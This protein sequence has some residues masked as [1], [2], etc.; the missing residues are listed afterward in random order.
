[1]SV[2]P[3]QPFR[4]SFNNQTCSFTYLQI[5]TKGTLS[6][7]SPLTAIHLNTVQRRSFSFLPF[8]SSIRHAM[9]GDQNEKMLTFVLSPNSMSQFE[10][11][12]SPGMT[13]TCFYN[14]HRAGPVSLKE[15]SIMSRTVV[16]LNSSMWYEKANPEI[17]LVCS[18]RAPVEYN[19]L[20]PHGALF[21]SLILDHQNSH[22][23]VTI[24]QETQGAYRLIPRSELYK[25]CVTYPPNVNAKAIEDAFIPWNDE[26]EE[27]VTQYPPDADDV[28][29]LHMRHGS[30]TEVS[31]P[32]SVIESQSVPEGLTPDNDDASVLTEAF[33]WLSM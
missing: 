6:L 8:I 9:Y 32:S 12:G 2:R 27:E 4:L 25:S 17:E 13:M 1:M 5:N 16:K 15:G 14:P 20:D 26:E 10:C 33:D 30:D 21:V 23:Y 24:V 19:S 22:Q 3:P 18:Q 7:N 31:C 28:S 29:L 11:M